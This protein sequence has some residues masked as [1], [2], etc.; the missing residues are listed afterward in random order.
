MVSAALY[1]AGGRHVNI[2]KTQ[3]DQSTV[4]KRMYG[5]KNKR[6]KISFFMCGFIFPFPSPCSMCAEFLWQ[7]THPSPCSFLF[8]FFSFLLKV[9]YLPISTCLC[10]SS[11]HLSCQRGSKNWGFCW[12]FESPCI[13]LYLLTKEHRK[14]FGC[15]IV[16]LKSLNSR[17]S[18]LIGLFI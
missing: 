16:G 10:L 15:L 9:L 18:C 6:S 7:E 17:L 11:L 5:K 13:I 8:S 12:G 1:F 3:R 4:E 2:E 14:G